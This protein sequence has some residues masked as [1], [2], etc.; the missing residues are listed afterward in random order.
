MDMNGA[1]QKVCFAIGALVLLD[2]WAIYNGIDGT[3]MLTTA[4]LV[5]G[6]GG[7]Q[8]AKSKA[9]TSLLKKVT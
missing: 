1:D 8:A 5:G 3:V 9:V 7:F 2:A 6:L 4:A